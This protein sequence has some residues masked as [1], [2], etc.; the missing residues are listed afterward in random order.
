MVAVYVDASALA[1]LI[2][3]RDQNYANAQKLLKHLQLEKASLITT[4]Y[5]ID[6]AATLL[7]TRSRNGYYYALA[8][9]NW[10]FDPNSNLRIEWVEKAIFKTAT[11]I[12]RRFNK[13]KQWPF[14]DCTSYVVMKELGIKTAF[15]FDEHFRQ[16]GFKIVE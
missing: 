6:E 10:V 15:T 7:L 11:K 13:D 9:L 3:S 12:F 4:D 5:I 1:A 8:M 2:N 16:M 14:T